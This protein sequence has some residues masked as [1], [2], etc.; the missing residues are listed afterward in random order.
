MRI[1]EV[2]TSTWIITAW[3]I[4]SLVVKLEELVC[5]IPEVRFF[6]SSCFLI[7]LFKWSYSRRIK[8]FPRL[9]LCTKVPRCWSRN[10][11]RLRQNNA[12]VPDVRHT[13]TPILNSFRKRFL[14]TIFSEG[15][16]SETI[17]RKCPQNNQQVDFKVL[18]WMFQCEIN[19]VLNSDDF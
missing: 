14:I 16:S 8:I 17:S 3:K 5:S 19:K 12:T 11:L 18:K 7:K 15:I 6:F 2:L 13:S 4:V 10:L 9:I 1:E